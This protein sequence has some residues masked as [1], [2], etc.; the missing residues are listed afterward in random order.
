MECRACNID[1]KQSRLALTRYEYQESVL[2][3]YLFAKLCASTRKADAK[4]QLLKFWWGGGSRSSV[5]SSNLPM[6]LNCGEIQAVYDLAPRDRPTY[7]RPPFSGGK[8]L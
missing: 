2:S 7:R 4:Q 8:S 3:P 5:E 1:L 6:N